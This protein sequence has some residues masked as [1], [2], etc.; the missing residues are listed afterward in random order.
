MTTTG[1]YELEAELEDEE[2]G[3]GILE[4]LRAGIGRGASRCA[5]FS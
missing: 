4:G 2:A 1:R 3:L 5:V